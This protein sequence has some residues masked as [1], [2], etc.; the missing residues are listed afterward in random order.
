[1]IWKTLVAFSTKRAN[2]CKKIR[3]YETL[4]LKVELGENSF[5]R[6][7]YKFTIIKYKFE[8]KL[9]TLINEQIASSIYNLKN[10]I[11]FQIG[12]KNAI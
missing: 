10:D 12:M 11:L 6:L 9:P 7:F 4:D 1:M 5:A 2:W 8:S 3:A